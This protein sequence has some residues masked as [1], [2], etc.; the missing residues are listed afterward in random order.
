VF[1]NRIVLVEFL[2]DFFNKFPGL[3]FWLGF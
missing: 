2:K 3:G 1:F